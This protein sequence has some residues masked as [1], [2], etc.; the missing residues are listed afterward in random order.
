MDKG[1]GILPFKLGPTKIVSHHHIFL[2]NINLKLIQ[3]KIDSIKAQVSIAAK[4][5]TNSNFVLFKYQVLH[6]FQKLDKIS[7]QLDSLQPSRSKRGLF[8]PLGSF[9]KSITGNLDQNDAQKYEN[10]L[11]ILQKNG[12]DFSDSFNRHVSLFKEFSSQQNSIL[13]S[14]S[15]N[16]ARL[17]KDFQNF[18]DSTFTQTEQIM[19]YAHMSQLFSL[20]SENIDDLSDEI[21]RL[22]NILAFS[23]TGT[24]HYYLIR[25]Y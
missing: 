8:N 23:R 3:Q 22:E 16:Q 14:L 20:I 12:K 7:V 21:S 15:S 11:Q 10:I 5:I 13:K 24:I 17:E 25:I 6:L 9:I 4:N 1:P 18:A 2:E 19:Y